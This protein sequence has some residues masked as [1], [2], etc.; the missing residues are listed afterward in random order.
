M[1]KYR[2]GRLFMEGVSVEALAGKYGTPLY[3]YSKATI[4]DR[5]TRIQKAFKRRAT[6]ICYALKAN[7]NKTL[8]RLLARRGAGADIVSGGELQR[9][10]AA[11]F[12]ADKIVF[13][14]V[15]KTE[16]EL[17]LALRRGVL[18]INVESAGE[19][20][21]LEKV[22]RRLKRRAPVSM[23]FNPDVDAHTHA[24]ITTGKAE[25]K[26]GLEESRAA[27]LYRKAHK[28]RWLRVKGIQCHIGS[29]ITEL[30]PYGQAARSVARMIGR[31]RGW[32]I[33]LELVDLGGGMGVS[34]HKETPL[35]PAGLASV[36]NEALGTRGTETLLLEP[37]RSLV[38]DSGILITRVLYRKE[39]SRKTFL[40]VDAGMNDL[41]R[42]ALYD[43]YHPIL[44]ADQG[45]NSLETVDVVGPVCE[46]GDFLAKGRKLPRS[47]P[48][49][50]LSVGKAGAYGFSMSS[51]YNSRPRAAE[52]LVEGRGSRLIRRR[53]TLKDIVRGEV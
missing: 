4:L 49:D 33:D 21:L 22:A 1:I 50:L 36:I 46:S 35:D 24:H 23:R 13:S 34:Y 2:A 32:G 44:P 15:G 51:Q 27:E 53:E 10:L 31:L 38:A 5:F 39:T 16:E 52:A 43:A 45:R 9:A 48:G 29:Q 19:L 40:I 7:T 30:G 28:S 8:C 47:R 14:G 41:A 3:A 25:N 18:T 11:G 12:P 26:F 42:P 17:I 20:E 6:L 37:G